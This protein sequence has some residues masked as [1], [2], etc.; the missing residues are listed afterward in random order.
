MKRFLTHIIMVSGQATPNVLAVMDKSIRPD[1]VVLCATDGM[2]RNA[3]ILAEYFKRHKIRTRHWELGSAYDFAALQDK[4]LNLAAEFSGRKSETGVNLTGGTKL[5]TIAAQ[6]VFW[7]DFPCFYINPERNTIQCI[8]EDGVPEYPIAGHLKI[9]DFF[10]IH[11]YR[12]VSLKR[13]E[14]TEKTERLCRTLF[15]ECSRYSD[16][17]RTLNYL[18][19]KTGKT[20]SARNDV[21][22]KSWELLKLFQDHGAIRYYDDKKIKFADEESR[23]F[24]R[25]VWLEDWVGRELRELNRRVKLQDYASSI[26]IESES[27]TSNEIDAAFLY[28]NRLYLIECKTAGLDEDAK[29]APPLYKLD[30]LHL[31]PGIF[32]GMILASYLPLDSYGKL[33]AADLGVKVVEM[34]TLLGLAT[35]LEKMICPKG[36]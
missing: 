17:L 33:R 15:G 29:S 13:K 28:N 2:C 1:E 36:R 31:R 21:P 16:S 30:S 3:E 23:L 32:T 7:Q 22:E 11:G 27:N 19:G 24:C 6:Q 4:F 35:C 34:G 20:L 18:A 10:A 12:V 8:T 26:V 5:M 25:G 14:A 9:S